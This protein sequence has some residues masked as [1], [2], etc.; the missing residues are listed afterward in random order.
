MP[1]HPVPHSP[2]LL[3]ETIGLL[4]PRPGE[5]VVDGTL[6]AGGHAEALLEAVG[7]SG[8]L[9]GIDRDPAALEIATRQ[10]ARFGDAFVAVRGDHSDLGT[11]LDR[12]GVGSI[13]RILLD[14]GVSSMQLVDPERGFSFSSDGPLD[15]RMDPQTPVSA[16]DLVATLSAADL[17]D[18][19]Q[20]LGEE[21]RAGAIA[22]A[23]VRERARAPIMRTGQLAEI[24]AKAAGPRG[25]AAAHP[26]GH[27]NLPGVAHRGQRRVGSACADDRRGGQPAASRRP[28]GRD[29]LSFAGGSHRQADLAG[30]GQPLH[31]PAGPAGLRLRA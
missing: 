15:M 23:I 1:A 19:I 11:L 29:L 25:P 13:D 21:R 20:R 4:D 12:Q 28:G 18:L 10:L 16:G 8:H 27:S 7:P 17:R 24:V 26:P 30:I 5:T 22:R 3:R 9:Y 31:L 6:G 2:V 14:L